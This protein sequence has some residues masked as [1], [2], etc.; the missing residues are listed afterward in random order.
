MKILKIRAAYI[1]QQIFSFLTEKRKLKIIKHNSYLKKKLEIS[2]IDYKIISSIK[3]LQNII[4]LIFT[5]FGF[6]LKMILN[7]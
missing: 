1:F 2:K 5:I 3:K 7:T 4:I 6:I